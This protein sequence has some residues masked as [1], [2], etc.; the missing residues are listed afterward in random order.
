MKIKFYLYFFALVSSLGTLAV[1]HADGEAAA[2]SVADI[3]NQSQAKYAALTSYSDEGSTVATL[4]PTTAS[5][6][7]F[8]IALARTNLYQVVWRQAD[9]FYLP[10][11]VVWSA[12]D[13]DFLWMGKNFKPQKY[14]DKDMALAAATGISG[15]ASSSVSGHIFRVELGQSTRPCAGWRTTQGRR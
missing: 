14:T 5:S 12:G 9:Q 6:Y 1:A 11:G 2:L 13:G 8:T 4:G 7:T 10:K 15:G 3:I